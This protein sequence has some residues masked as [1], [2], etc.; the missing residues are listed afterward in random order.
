[1]L[2]GI[3]NRLNAL[4]KAMNAI[5]LPA[6]DPSN[7]LAKEQASLTLGHLN[8]LLQQ[9]DKA[10]VYELGNYVELRQLASQIGAVAEGGEQTRTTCEVLARTLADSPTELPFGSE[11]L[12]QIAKALGDAIDEVLYASH[13]DGTTAYKD[14][15]E[16]IMLAYGEKQ[17]MRQRVWFKCTGLEQSAAE[18]ESVDTMLDRIVA[19]TGLKISI[20]A[21]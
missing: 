4:V 9:W 17:T 1:M 18:L 12:N 5:I 7:D 2:P 11:P 15:L 6:V 10:Y 19:E 3:T 8:V 14:K 16:E 20:N 21:S 13:E